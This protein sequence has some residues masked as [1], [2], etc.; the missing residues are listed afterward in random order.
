MKSF[1]E[2]AIMT[3]ARACVKHPFVTLLM[4]AGAVA[5]FMYVVAMHIQ[6]QNN[7]SRIWFPKEDLTYAYYDVFKK[8][9]ESDENVIVAIR[10]KDGI[11]NPKTL[12]IIKAVEEELEK[13]PNV[14]EVKSVLSMNHVMGIHEVDESGED[15][16]ELKIE[17]VFPEDAELTPEVIEEARQK[18]LADENFIGNILS[19]DGHFAAIFGRIVATDDMHI[20]RQ[21]TLDSKAALER[22]E[23][24]FRDDGLVFN[25]NTNPLIDLRAEEFENALR[26][27][28]LAGVPIFDYEFDALSVADQEEMSPLTL[29]II[30]AVLLFMFRSI[31]M[32][33][34]PMLLMF[35]VVSIAFG[36]YM[37][38]GNKMNM[39]VGMCGPVLIVA[40]V[41]DSVHLMSTYYLK[42]AV[43]VSRKE[44]ILEACREV[45]WP[46]LFTSL[47]TSAGFITFVGAYVPPMKGFGW[48]TS[49]GT[50]MAYLATFTLIPAIVSALDEIDVWLKKRGDS[51]F[52]RLIARPVGVLLREPSQEA[53]DSMKAGWVSRA[54]DNTAVSTLKRTGAYLAFLIVAVVVAVYGSTK[55]KVESNNADFI[56]KTHYVRYA[57]DA[58]QR[59][60]TGVSNIEI[61]FEGDEGFAKNP[62]V[63]ARVDRMV[64][65]MKGIPF[66][67][68][69]F[70]H[71]VYLKQINRAMHGGEQE[72]FTVPDSEPLI[73][74]Y[75]LLAELSGDKDIKSFVNYDYSRIRVTM[76]SSQ[77]QSE[78]FKLLVSRVH[79][80]VNHYLP[81]IRQVNYRTL[82]KN[83]HGSDPEQY[84][85][86]IRQ[87][88]EPP[89]YKITGLIPLYSILDRM[90]VETLLNSF[91]QSFLLVF[92]C[93]LIMTRS[94]KLSAMG[95]VP[96]V[97]P[98]IITGGLLGYSGWKLDPAT[99]LIAAMVLGLAVDNAIHYV[100]RF[101][102]FIKTS[103]GNYEQAIRLTAH[104]VGR[105]LIA[106]AFILVLGFGVMVFG[107]FYPTRNFGM[108]ASFNMMLAIMATLVFMPVLYLLIKPYARTDGKGADNS[109]GTGSN[110]EKLPAPGTEA[111]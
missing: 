35:F 100:A 81:D 20:K 106:T 87:S 82:Q 61:I 33:V 28:Y 71:T 13:I 74:Q 29:G 49:L 45:N 76:R 90:F 47:T 65:E 9:F 22:I 31:P 75:L 58:V 91:S 86:S 59:D 53:L 77:N 88:G 79:G 101:D 60:L 30:L 68:N 92:G 40:C 32:A 69:V 83:F 56:P 97:F 19:K 38:V 41:G 55:I 105:A 84:V 18:A 67:S 14:E 107:S 16:Y 48:V 24:R 27:V 99:I 36:T 1:F 15:Q 73:A 63:L 89:V 8:E 57:M 93:L 6:D 98:I 80:L 51:G 7:S 25:Q 85:M 96:A 72:Y 26:Q 11:F 95:M 62:D 50:A 104:H 4:L 52:A 17:P 43:G 78:Q 46:C 3:L 12:E 54:L 34:I 110:G 102:D 108:M 70:S 37:A 42:R 66:V 103:N 64:E 94:F 5:P 44:T 111:A 109:T 2:K 23:D 10:A 39:L 21:I